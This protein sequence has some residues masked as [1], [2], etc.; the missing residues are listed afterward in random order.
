MSLT[1]R[2]IAL[3]VLGAGCLTVSLALPAG[4]QVPALAAV[5]SDLPAGYTPQLAIS[6]GFPHPA[7]YALKEMGST[8]YAGGAFDT[9]STGT[10]TVTRQHLMGFSATTGDLSGLSI[11]IDGDVWAI[12]P[13]TDGQ[14]LYVGGFF[15]NI[16]GVARNGIAK[17]NATTGVVDPTFAS[18]SVGGPVTEIRLVNGRLI[19]GGR[20]AKRLVALDPSTGQ[21]TNYINLGISGQIAGNSGPT[22]VYRFAVNPQSSRLVGI[23][24]FTSVGGQARQRAFMLDLGTASATLDS[25]YYTPLNNACA[26]TKIPEQLRDVDFSSDGSFFVFFASGYVPTS[27]AGLGRDI[28]DAAARF[29]TSIPNP[30]LPTWINYTGGDTI[31]SGAVTGNTVYAQG[32]FRALDNAGGTQ[33]CDGKNPAC[34]PRQGIGAIDATTGKA[35]D[36]NPGKSRSVGGKDLLV[37]QGG[38]WVGSD[39]ALFA[40]KHRYGI[41]FCPVVP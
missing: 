30:Q 36:W 35:L 5:V 13:S 28:C 17:I 38:L 3:A 16:N 11:P 2:R 9:V 4:A 8:M 27:P 19:V 26:A 41:A 10:G 7:V 24:N 37:T 23:G 34:K 40:G 18:S 14:S 12:E 15:K 25:W 29:E 6:T 20:F 31:W 1:F 22:R 32:H 33:G 21:D 39:G